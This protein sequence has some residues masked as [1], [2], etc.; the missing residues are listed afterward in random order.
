MVIEEKH[1]CVSWSF[2][3]HRRW[4]AVIPYLALFPHKIISWKA[5]KVLIWGVT[6]SGLY[7][8]RRTLAGARGWTGV[9]AVGAGGWPAGPFD[10]ATLL[11]P[12]M[13]RGGSLRREPPP[14][15]AATNPNAV[16]LSLVLLLNS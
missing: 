6:G 8:A 7:C 13:H 4:H 15:H 12:A 14:A 5:L 3:H 11:M 9:G 10:D 1:I 16:C 2:N